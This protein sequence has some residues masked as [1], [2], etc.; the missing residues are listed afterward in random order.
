M[1]RRARGKGPTSIKEQVDN[2]VPN[3][4]NWPGVLHWWQTSRMKRMLITCALVVAA[5]TSTLSQ[6]K[7]QQ[8]DRNKIGSNSEAEQE[9]LAMEKELVKAGLRG[10]AAATDRLLA[11]DYFFMTR[12]GMV[13]ENLK[14]ALLV[15]MKSGQS[16]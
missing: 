16:K 11:D 3:A 12:D 15:R 10:D 4:R 8:A 7:E 13:H 2:P 6:T 9:I 5:A 14:T 1:W